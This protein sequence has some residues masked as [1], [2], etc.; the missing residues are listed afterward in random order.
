MGFLL[1]KPRGDSVLDSIVRTI[2]HYAAVASL[3]KERDRG[4]VEKGFLSMIQHPGR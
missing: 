2:V 1:R 3:V 4:T